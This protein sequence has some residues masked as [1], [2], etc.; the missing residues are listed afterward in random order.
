MSGSAEVTQWFTGA[1]V[2]ALVQINDKDTKQPIGDLTGATITARLMKQ[3]ATAFDTVEQVGNPAAQSDSAD[4]ADWTQALIAVEFDAAETGTWTNSTGKGLWLQIK[5]VLS[6]KT[7]LYQTN[8][9][10]EVIEGF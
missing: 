3:S 4:N 8:R 6:G 7:K 1:D 5:V 2:D 9:F 10:I